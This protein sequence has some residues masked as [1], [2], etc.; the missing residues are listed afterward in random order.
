[1]LTCFTDNKFCDITIQITGGVQQIRAHTVAL[2]S[3]SSV[4]RKLQTDD[5][6]LSI[7]TV[8]DLEEEIIVALINLNSEDLVRGTGYDHNYRG[9]GRWSAGVGTS[10][11]ELFERVLQFVRI[12]IAE[13]KTRDV[14]KSAMFSH[15]ELA[16][17]LL[18]T[19]L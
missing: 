12:N 14:W 6:Q 2:V 19:I 10:I 17:Q 18:N 9:F 11:P 5:E 1:M 16:F 3:G 15:P 8:S 7:I 4:W 13:L